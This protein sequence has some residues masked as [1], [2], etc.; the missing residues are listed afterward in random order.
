VTVYQQTT[1]RVIVID[2]ARQVGWSRWLTGWQVMTIN[3]IGNEAILVHNITL[4]KSPES[5]DWVLY[6]RLGSISAISYYWGK[7]KS[8]SDSISKHRITT[9]VVNLTMW[10]RRVM[11]VENHETPACQLIAD[12]PW[13]IVWEWSFHRLEQT[14]WGCGRGSPSEV[15][16]RCPT[17]AEWC[18][19][20]P[21]ETPA[22]CPTPWPA[23]CRPLGHSPLSGCPGCVHHAISI[24]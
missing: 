15:E 23:S 3:N 21:S 18:C 22:Q 4:V 2:Q 9:I 16:A 7:I 20:E 13:A 10:R 8:C 17:P 14:W 12:V 11:R 5:W 19:A 6:A 24:I 1:F